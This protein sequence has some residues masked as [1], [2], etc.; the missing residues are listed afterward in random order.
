MKKIFLMAFA[1]LAIAS[2]V[3][4]KPWVGDGSDGGPIDYT[5]LV[6]NE[7][8]GVNKVVELY[9]TGEVAIKLQGV[10]LVKNN[11]TGEALFWKCN[12]PTASIPAGGYVLVGE[13]ES[14]PFTGNGGISSKKNVK[15]ELF[16]PANASLGVFLRI[17]ENVIAIDGNCSDVAPNSFQRVPNGTGDWMMA[18]PTK[19]AANAATGTAIPQD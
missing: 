6:L 17:P 13:G 7:V 14:S 9:N 16:T 12:T 11:E 1:A 15:F 4:D 5:K 19:G 10:Y 3:E 18:A 8:D 2:C